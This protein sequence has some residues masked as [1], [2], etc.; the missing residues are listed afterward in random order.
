[1]CWLQ[2]LLNIIKKV[3]T[4][5]VITRLDE[6]VPH[7][8]RNEE[9]WPR[10]LLLFNT[11]SCP[12]ELIVYLTRL[13]FNYTTQR[14]SNHLSLAFVETCD[15]LIKTWKPRW[16]IWCWLDFTNLWAAQVQ[17]DDDSMC[18][19]VTN[20][21]RSELQLS[22]T[23]LGVC[24]SRCWRW[25]DIKTASKSQHR[26]HTNETKRLHCNTWNAKMWSQLVALLGR[27]STAG[28]AQMTDFMTALH[29]ILV[30][31]RCPED[32]RLVR[33]LSRC[34]TGRTDLRSDRSP[35]SDL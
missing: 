13:T 23:L 17:R 30:Q 27:S 29:L 8:V 31:L 11:F 9:F 21:R 18:K 22:M 4:P 1:M 7:S 6:F 2:I 28:A 12:E 32:Q 35:G 24:A 14:V 25:S 15:S 16:S 5:P 10:S 33:S 3:K 19:T 20:Q 34:G 26:T